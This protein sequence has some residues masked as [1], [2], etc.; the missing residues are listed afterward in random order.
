MVKHRW[1]ALSVRVHIDAAALATD[2]ELYEKLV[3]PTVSG[4][5]GEE[6]F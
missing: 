4:E 1:G 2:V 6:C 3:F 5:K